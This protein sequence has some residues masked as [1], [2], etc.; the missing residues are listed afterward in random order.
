M[1]TAPAAGSATNT[2][3]ASPALS[4]TPVALP[5]GDA[6]VPVV[7]QA[8]IAKTAGPSFDCS[9]ATS[10]TALTICSNSGLRDLDR[11]MAILYYSR[12]DYATDQSVRDE[13]RAWLRGRNQC[14]ADVICLRQ[15]YA[16][17]IQQLQQ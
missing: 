1:T 8:V 7:L 4:P 13:Q 10:A 6:G 12:T 11:Q 5:A 15:E 2:G 14:G 17:R 3:V 9:K 16:A